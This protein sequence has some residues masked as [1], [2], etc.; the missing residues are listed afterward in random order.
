[1]A[2]LGH[3]TVITG[4]SISINSPT[5]TRS[6]SGVIGIEEPLPVTQA[7]SLTT[8]T[9]DTVGTITMTSG[10]HTIATG[11]IIDIYWAGGV[12]YGVTVGTV[13]TTAVPITEGAGD[14]LPIA[15]TAVTVVPQYSINV[16]IDGDE[17]ELIVLI[18]ETTVN[19]LRT[20]GHVQFRDASNNEIAAIELVTNVPKVY[21]ITGGATNPFTGAPITNAK[22]SQ[23]SGTASGH[24][25][26]VVGVQDASP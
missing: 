12:R 15:A 14:N 25:L 7:G 3:K 19:T 23:A 20:A 10:D 2:D 17:A 24:V 8:R 16:A 18:L 4:G 26:K 9:G 11:N 21:D 13:S 6:G 5:I 1:M 22:A